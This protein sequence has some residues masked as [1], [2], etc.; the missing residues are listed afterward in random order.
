MRNRARDYTQGKLALDDPAVSP[1]YAD[2]TG[3]P[4]LHLQVGE[5]DTVRGGALA[6]ADAAEKDGVDITLEHWPGCIHGWHGLAN[7]GVPEAGAAWR[8]IRAYLQRVLQ[9]NTTEPATEG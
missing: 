8:A 9:L 2:F 4:P 7:A 5:H 6:G 3:L 1:A